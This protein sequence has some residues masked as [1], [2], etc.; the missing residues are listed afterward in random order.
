MESSGFAG[1][2]RTAGECPFE[3]LGRLVDPAGVQ[4]REVKRKPSI[5]PG[6]EIFPHGL[7]P[8]RVEVVPHDVDTTLGVSPRDLLHEGHEIGLCTPVLATAEDATG[9]HVEGT[10]LFQTA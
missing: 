5:V 9:V 2:E 6:I 1:L 4:R 8:V 7:R 10:S 3:W